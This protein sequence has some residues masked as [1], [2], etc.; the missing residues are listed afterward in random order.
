MTTTE[1]ADLEL[2]LLDALENANHPLGKPLRSITTGAGITQV[3][4]A[5]Y[6]VPPDIAEAYEALAEGGF[7]RVGVVK[8]ISGRH[9]ITSQT[10]HATITPEGRARLSS[11]RTIA[12]TAGR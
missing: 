7:C 10:L 9:G 12:E 4:S 3:G 5:G 1:T 11:L 8:N 2:R 6:L